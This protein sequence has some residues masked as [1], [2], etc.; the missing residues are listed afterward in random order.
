MCY[1]G[2]DVLD[3]FEYQALQRWVVS[4]GSHKIKE[5]RERLDDIAVNTNK[6]NLESNVKKVSIMCREMTNSFVHASN[7]WLGSPELSFP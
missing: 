3:E 7:V 6:F 1:D 2:E 4:H 5:I